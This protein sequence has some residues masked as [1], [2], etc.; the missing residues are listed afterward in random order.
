[1][2]GLVPYLLLPGTAREALEFYQAVFGGE[3]VLHEYGEFGRT[4]GPAD[5]IAHGMLRGVVELFASDAG[6]DDDAIATTGLMFALLGVA[7]ADTTTAW[8]AALSEGGR[9][10]DP[11]Q[12]RPWEGN[13]GQVRDRFG[14]HWLLGFED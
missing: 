13:D 10:L 1:M 9:V 7:D 5:A 8:F 12:H 2:A 3:L 14:V 4:D 6:A 11:L